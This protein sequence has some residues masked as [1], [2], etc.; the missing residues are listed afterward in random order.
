MKYEAKQ[1]GSSNV[2]VSTASG[3]PWVNINLNDATNNSK[4]VANC[5]SC[6]L[7]SEAEWLTITQNVL[8]EPSNWN[9]DTVGSGYIYSGHNDGMPDNSLEADAND[10]NDHVGETNTIDDSQK[11]TL[12]LS[13]GEIIWDFAGNVREVTSGTINSK[14]Q[15]GIAGNAYASW[16]DWKDV[17]TLGTL[18]PDPSPSGT[19]IAGAGSWS[20]SSSS[21]IGQLISNP[22]NTSES[23]FFRGGFWHDGYAAGVLSLCLN[24]GPGFSPKSFVG[25][26][27]AR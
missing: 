11:R 19:G 12:K 14:T 16:I 18:S 20:G 25:F 4:N 10:N 9:T 24:N 5:S 15:P 3:Y 1:V 27:V 13:D 23:A 7:I 17:T 2:P 22:A 21:G 26:R 6:H 8:K